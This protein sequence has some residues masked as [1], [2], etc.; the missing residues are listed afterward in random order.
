MLSNGPVFYCENIVEP[1]RPVLFSHTA[2]AKKAE[3]IEA[4]VERWEDPM[5]NCLD[6]VFE[7]HKS[8]LASVQAGHFGK[9]SH[10]L[11]ELL[12]STI[13]NLL[14]Q[15]FKSALVKAQGVLEM[16]KMGFTLNEKDFTTHQSRMVAYYKRVRSGHRGQQADDS[17]VEMMS[18]VQAYFEVAHKRFIDNISLLVEFD[19]IQGLQS[20]IPDALIDTVNLGAPDARSRC[21]QLLQKNVA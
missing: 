19:F 2:A 15:N 6:L 18:E 3:L 11:R 16:E 4:F 12:S 10:E 20:K 5:K 21:V 7:N 9:Y 13:D 14:S 8:H 1:E 17:V